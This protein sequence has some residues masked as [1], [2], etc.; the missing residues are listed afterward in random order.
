[1]HNS[2]L[3]FSSQ[4]DTQETIKSILAPTFP[5]IIVSDV[6]Q[7]LSALKQKAVPVLALVGTNLDDAAENFTSMRSIS[8]ALT[9]IAIGE[10]GTEAEAAEAV[11]H[12]ATGYIMTPL[13]K[14]V[15]MTLA[16]KYAPQVTG[17]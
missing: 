10:I 12:G 17:K 9:I 6:D 16:Q 1:M 15:I 3:I 5:L 11:S 4:E 13:R 2:I 7:A 14:D 8:P